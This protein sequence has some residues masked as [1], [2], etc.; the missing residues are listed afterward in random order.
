MSGFPVKTSLEVRFRDLDPLGHV[1]NAVY[2]SY[3]ELGRRHYFRAVEVDFDGGSMVLAR[4]EV[5]FSR[6][7]LI[8]ERVEVFSRVVS[9]GN[10]S[11]KN[12]CE[13]RADGELA[14][15]LLGVVVWLEGGRPAR[16]PDVL[17]E[18]IRR[19]EAAV[20]NVVAGLEL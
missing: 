18:R 3:A 2:L 19:L 17:R 14:A 20:G 7:I 12:L 15:R 10:T 4:A 11:L 16:V 1:N 13:I 5:D 9:V 8:D 6:P